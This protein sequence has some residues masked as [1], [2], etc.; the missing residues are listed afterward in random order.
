MQVAREAGSGKGCKVLLI[1]SAHFV[2]EIV[3]IVGNN[4][5]LSY[6]VALIND[7]NL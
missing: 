1:T 6:V 5:S 7:F 4:C 3:I 2:G